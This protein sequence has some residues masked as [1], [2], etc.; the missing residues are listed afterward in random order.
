MH[1]T[2]QGCAA[3]L[4]FNLDEVG[5][6]DWEDRKPKT[7]GVPITARAQTIHSRISRNVKHISVVSCTSAGGVCFSPVQSDMS[8][9]RRSSPRPGGHWDAKEEG[10]DLKSGDIP[11]IKAN[12]FE[13][14][15]QIVFRPRPASTR[16]TRNLREKDGRWVMDNCS[17]LLARIVVKLPWTARVRPITFAAHAMQI[18]QIFDLTRLEC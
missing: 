11:S 7:V 16:P 17:P 18:F 12:L 6:S 4:V 14:C 5:I 15:I 8:R 9:I 13:N 10:F 2:I 3:D 1:K